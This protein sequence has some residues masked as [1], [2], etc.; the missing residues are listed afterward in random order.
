[1]DK[2]EECKDQLL[3]LVAGQTVTAQLAKRAGQLADGYWGAVNTAAG[4]GPRVG[5]NNHHA[6]RRGGVCTV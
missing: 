3:R 2:P 6:T 5:S 1:M 4:D